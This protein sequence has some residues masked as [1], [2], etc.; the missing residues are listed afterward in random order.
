VMCFFPLYG[1]LR[2]DF[3]ASIVMLMSVFTKGLRLIVARASIEIK[4]AAEPSSGRGT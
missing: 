4:I 2:V 3:F 1:C